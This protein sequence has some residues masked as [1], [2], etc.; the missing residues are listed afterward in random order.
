L[1]TEDGRKFSVRIDYPKGDPENP[2]TWEELLGKFDDLTSAI[3]P[4]AGRKKIISRVQALEQEPSMK[5][6][7]QLVTA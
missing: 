3:Y 6:F 7:G 2:L 5:G 1:A 4:V